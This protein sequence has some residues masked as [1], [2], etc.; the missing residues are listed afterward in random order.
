MPHQQGVHEH[1]PGKKR[2]ELGVAL[3][4]GHALVIAQLEAGNDVDDQV[5]QQQGDGQHP[6]HR[7]AVVGPCHRR[8]DQITGAK[9]GQNGD[10][11]GPQQLEY[12]GKT[13]LR[14]R[15]DF[16]FDGRNARH[17]RYL[18]YFFCENGRIPTQYVRR[19][20]TTKIKRV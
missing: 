8:S 4:D 16:A 17:G 14:G 20:T 2:I 12:S 18:R 10:D 11:S 5:S 3:E 1:E 9:P 19:R 7:V 15:R 13:I 6:H